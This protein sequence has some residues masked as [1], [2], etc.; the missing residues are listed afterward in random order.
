MPSPLLFVGGLQGLSTATSV[1][2][3]LEQGKLNKA[4]FEHN[5]KMAEFDAA[6]SKFV[7][8]TNENR[9]NEDAARLI[10]QTRAEAGASGFAV[11]GGSNDQVIADINR[12]VAIDAAAIRTQGAISAFKSMSDAAQSSIDASN[13]IRASRVSAATTILGDASRYAMAYG[14]GK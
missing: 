8:E 2:T 10:G 12:N 11:D 3:T 6:Y 9:L 13:A 1:L 7:A 14:L 5:A 4:T